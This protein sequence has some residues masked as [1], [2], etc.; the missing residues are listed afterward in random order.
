MFVSHTLVLPT[1]TRARPDDG[2]EPDMTAVP[3]VRIAEIEVEP[4]IFG[5]VVDLVYNAVRV[6]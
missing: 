5:L 4:E 1:V 3:L 6:V 2:A